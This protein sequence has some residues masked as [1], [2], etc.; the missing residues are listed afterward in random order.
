VSKPFTAADIP[1][2]K[3]ADGGAQAATREF[4]QVD[5]N[6][7][8]L[9]LLELGVEFYANHLRRERYETFGELVVLCDLAGARTVGANVL[10]RATFNF[11]SAV[12]R[13]ERAKHLADMSKAPELDWPR[14]LEE[15]CVRVLTAQE[16][17]RPGELLG[18]IPRPVADDVFDVDG[19]RLLRRHP[20]VLFGDGGAAKSYLA[21]YMGGCLAQRGLRVALFDWELA[22]E[23]HRDRLE[24]LFG[25]RMPD[26][27]Y[28]RCEQPLI[29][30]ATRLARFAREKRLDF[31][32]YDSV[33][34]AAHDKPEAPD[35]ALS[36]FRAVRQI[37]VG[38]AHIAHITKSLEGNEEKPFGSVFWHNGA[39]ATY[40]MQRAAEADDG[41]TVGVFNKKFN[42]GPKLPPFGFRFVFEPDRT[43][44][45]RT[46]VADVDELATKLPLV[47]RMRHLLK[48]GAMTIV[49]I[50]DQLDAK[51][52][53][54]TKTAKR[55]DGKMFVRV[56]GSDGVYRIGLSERH[57]A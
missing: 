40:F 22:G 7:Y 44:V 39:R 52:D 2:A 57:V 41:M 31:A 6:S 45:T 42:T 12:A 47:H 37:G 34:F 5:E 36:Y 13:K 29:F 1:F 3:P 20:V 54:V 51:V 18:D 17:G 28:V 10:N 4:R 33:G 38:S 56:S 48:G 8:V 23:D 19:L 25:P 53:S 9:S 35:S 50:A 16:Q 55:Y 15:V 49:A 21:L 43:L 14:L 11:S 46:N 26:V 30:E 27:W 24:R 32:L